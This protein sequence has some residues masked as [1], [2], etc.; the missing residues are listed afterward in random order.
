[1]QSADD[2]IIDPRRTSIPTYRHLRRLGANVHLTL[3][4]HVDNLTGRYHDA[5]G[6]PLRYRGHFC[7]IEVYH[8]FVDRDADGSPVTVGGR[9]VS[10]W[11]WVGLQRR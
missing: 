3:F 4:D 10:L 6:A 5:S 2:D 11:E 7:W 8:D 9:P 1:M